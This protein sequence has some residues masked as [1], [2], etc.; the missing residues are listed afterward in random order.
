MRHAWVGAELDADANG[1]GG[2]PITTASSRISAWVIPTNE[3]QM[4][5]RH[6]R[7]VLQ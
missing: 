3:E 7:A 1:K 5:A 2:P 6:T 4:I